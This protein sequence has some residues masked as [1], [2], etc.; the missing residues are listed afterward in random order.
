MCDAGV[1]KKAEGHNGKCAAD[2]KRDAMAALRRFVSCV[3]LSP[4]SEAASLWRLV[5]EADSD[6]DAA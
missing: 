1:P 4:E 2:L 3:Q 5:S 6:V